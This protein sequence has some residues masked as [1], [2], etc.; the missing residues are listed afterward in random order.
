MKI[1]GVTFSI[2]RL[3]GVDKVKR[4][5]SRETGIPTT[6]SGLERKA[7]KFVLSFLKK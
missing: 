6:K 5:I 3:L 7:G 4:K 1:P 2:R